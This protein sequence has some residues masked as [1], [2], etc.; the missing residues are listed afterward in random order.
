MYGCTYFTDEE[1]RPRD[2][3][4]ISQDNI[5]WSSS[6]LLSAPQQVTEV[7]PPTEGRLLM[8]D[9]HVL[10]SPCHC[11]SFCPS[12]LL[13]H[14]LLS[15][16]QTSTSSLF[17]FLPWLPSP[18]LPLYQWFSS[19]FYPK[20]C[21]LHYLLPLFCCP[22][23]PQIKVGCLACSQPLNLSRLSKR[24]EDREVSNHFPPHPK[25]E[26]EPSR[27]LYKWTT[28]TKAQIS[29][30]PC[31]KKLVVPGFTLGDSKSK[32]SVKIEGARVP[33]VYFTHSLTTQYILLSWS[34]HASRERQ[35]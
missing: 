23:C 8:C 29:L 3:S 32:E 27:R 31:L 16:P 12:V 5:G 22:A 20:P 24:A 2:L 17:S 34:L 6:A 30:K 21:H 33:N 1:T 15:F 10:R 26:N 9:W 14:L 28:R 13:L 35:L 19:N 11:L 18:S 25:L 7:F 4:E